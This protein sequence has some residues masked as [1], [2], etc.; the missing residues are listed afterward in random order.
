MEKRESTFFAKQPEQ[1]QVIDKKDSLAMMS[2]EELVEYAAQRAHNPEMDFKIIPSSLSE[3]NSDAKIVSGVVSDS[4][5]KEVD[6]LIASVVG[7][8]ETDNLM[9]TITT[10]WTKTENYKILSTFDNL[11]FQL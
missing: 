10:P 6:S 3:E 1:T 4:F 11:D 2:E 5:F 7:N 9:F 8:I